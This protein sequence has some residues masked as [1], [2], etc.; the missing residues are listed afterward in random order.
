MLIRRKIVFLPY[1]SAYKTTRKYVWKEV[2]LIL[3]SD[4]YELIIK[5]LIALKN[6]LIRQ[7]YYTGAVDDILIKLLI[8]KK[9]KIK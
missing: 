6:H 8:T 3:T 9:V 5:S 1:L 4:E 2:S 7:G